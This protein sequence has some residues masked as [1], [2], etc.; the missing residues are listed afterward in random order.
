MIGKARTQRQALWRAV[1]LAAIVPAAGVG[2]SEPASPAAPPASDEPQE[3]PAE[4]GVVRVFFHGL[5][6]ESER[7]LRRA[8]V[9]DLGDVVERGARRADVDDTAFE[10]ETTLLRKGYAHADVSW[11][12]DERERHTEVIFTIDEGPRARWKDLHFEGSQ[13]FTDE[14][15]EELL[16][17]QRSGLL[18]RGARWFV[19][20]DYR[21]LPHRV[22]TLYRSRGFLSVRVEAGAVTFGSNRSEASA[23]VQVEEGPRSTIGAI[24]GLDIGDTHVAEWAALRESLL[25]TWIGVPYYPRRTAEIRARILERLRRAGHLDARAEVVEEERAADHSVRLRATVEPGPIVRLDAVIVEGND[26]TSAAFLRDRVDLEQGDVLGEEQRQRAF[27]RLY[28]TG[29]F[30]RVN[31]RVEGTGEQRALRVSVEERDSLELYLRPGF[32]SYEKARIEVG[33]E[34]SNLFGTGRKADLSAGISQ[35]GEWGELLLVDPWLIGSEFSLDLPLR[36]WRREEPSFVDVQSSVGIGL[37]RSIRDHLDGS[38]GYE[39]RRSESRDVDL[40]ALTPADLDALEEDATIGTLAFDL[41]H[42]TRDS[43]FDPHRGHRARVGIEWA[44]QLLGSELD[45]VRI[46]G[47]FSQHFELRS[48]TVLAIG[49][50]STLALPTGRT[51]L[52]PLPE[53]AFNGGENTVRSFAESELGPSDVFGEPIGGEARNVFN[54]ELRQDL[55]GPLQGALFFDS[56]NAVLDSRDYL[57]DFRHAVGAGLHYHLPIGAIRLDFA[58]NP[59]RRRGEDHFRVHFSVGLA[60]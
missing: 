16:G 3:T 32:G 33:M 39:L 9:D 1:A 60:F 45:F 2:Q 19:E 30:R 26:S 49:L 18:R 42:D 43:L 37:R 17:S 46:N 36:Y 20:E 51:E 4:P 8:V 47:S 21:A 13:E 7:E 48:S 6:E 40:A 58:Q 34:E 29:L 53:R 59:A 27:R 22:A 14:E 5:E 12:I 28:A 57:R 54:L 50:R 56:G 11:E 25:E 10:L 41:V 55:L 38:L 44:D 35:V 23:V 15:L 24:E 31:L 52:L